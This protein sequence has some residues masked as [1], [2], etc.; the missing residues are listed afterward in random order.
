[1]QSKNSRAPLAVDVAV[2]GSG[3]AGLAAVLEARRAGASV[4]LIEKAGALG[5]ATMLSGGGCLIAGSPLQEK[6]GIHDSADLAYEDRIKW[7][8]DA[9]DPTPPER[10]TCWRV[11]GTGS[12]FRRWVSRETNPGLASHRHMIFANALRGGTTSVMSP[13]ANYVQLRTID[14]DWTRAYRVNEAVGLLCVF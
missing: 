6:Q 1:M 4:A 7:G 13:D 2:V 11:G 5:G 10:D 8:E 12:R 9:A 14:D 3:G